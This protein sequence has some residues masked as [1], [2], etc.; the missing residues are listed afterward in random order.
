MQ[1]RIYQMIS[2][3]LTAIKNCETSGNYEWEVIHHE[4]IEKAVSDHLPSGG[5][6]DGGT[7]LN[8]DLSKPDR[9]VF[10]TAFHHMDAN[11]YYDGWSH[12]QVVVKP[13]LAH[14]KELRITG[15][16]RND[17]K[18]YIHDVFDHALD[19]DPYR[20]DVRAA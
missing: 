1:Q 20:V 8:F 4:R 12:H 9:L 2:S 16:N 10:D 14:G 7:S 6:F 3:L 15:L 5:G 18:D 11:G 13:N 17:I 19:A